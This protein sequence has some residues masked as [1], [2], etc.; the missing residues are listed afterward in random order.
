MA[1][2]VKRLSDKPVI[3]KL[4][5]EGLVH[6]FMCQE[7]VFNTPNYIVSYF[8]VIVWIF[9]LSCSRYNGQIEILFAY[10]M[11]L[12]YHHYV[13]IRFSSRLFLWDYNLNRVTIFCIFYLMVYNAYTPQYFPNWLN[14]LFFFKL[15]K[16]RRISYNYGSLCETLFTLK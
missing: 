16:I 1:G 6:Y 2:W 5:G 4:G 8:E 15:Y 9:R 10:P 7:F 3:F 14:K 11:A 13:Y 12:S